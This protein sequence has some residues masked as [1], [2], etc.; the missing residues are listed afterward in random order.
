MEKFITE[1][2]L[3]ALLGKGMVYE[4]EDMEMEYDVDIPMA[5]LG[6]DNESESSNVVV[7]GKMKINGFK[8]EIHKD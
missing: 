7:K 4:V 5:V 3:L 1:K 8:F 2:V 6:L